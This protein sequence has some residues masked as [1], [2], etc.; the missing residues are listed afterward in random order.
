MNRAG[1]CRRLVGV[2][3]MNR[4]LGVP[5]SLT[6]QRAV[7]TATDCRPINCRGSF[8]EPLFDHIYRQC[9]HLMTTI[10]RNRTISRLTILLC[11]PWNG[12]HPTRRRQIMRLQR[13]CPWITAFPRVHT[14]AGP[15]AH[16]RRVNTLNTPSASESDWNFS[17]NKKIIIEP[18]L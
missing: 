2:R 9:Q 1:A 12:R 6:N 13:Q 18:L 7:D 5:I 8:D 15:T 3:S 4:A 16:G 17:P 11:R 14:P 10:H